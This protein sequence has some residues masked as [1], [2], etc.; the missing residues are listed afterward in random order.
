MAQSHKLVLKTLKWYFFWTILLTFF[1]ISNIFTLIS[2]KWLDQRE[3]YFYDG[4]I[5]TIIPAILNFGYFIISFYNIQKDKSDIPKFTFLIP[6]LANPLL[7]FSSFSWARWSYRNF[8]TFQ[9]LFILNA[10][11][12]GL[13]FL[14]FIFSHKNLHRTF[15]RA[16]PIKKKSNVKKHQTLPSTPEFKSE[17]VERKHTVLKNTQIQKLQKMI[18]VSDQLTI[19]QFCIA[20]NLSKKE[21]YTYLFDWADKFNFK[22]NKETLIFQNSNIDGF[23]AELSNQFSEW[24]TPTHTLNK[25]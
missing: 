24:E 25:I 23:V 17:T 22:I 21:I 20:L 9:A 18:K 5:L 3:L 11:C 7:I 16:Q 10:I 2:H 6:F 12:Y 1:S 14:I 4:Y 8:P 15:R 19:D 13:T